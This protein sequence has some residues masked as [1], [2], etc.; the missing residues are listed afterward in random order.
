MT[1][2]GY[3]SE[4]RIR[5]AYS[6]SD[7]ALSRSP[8]SASLK[9]RAVSMCHHPP[10][11]DMIRLRLPLDAKMQ[12]HDRFL[13]LIN[14]YTYLHQPGNNERIKW[15]SSIKQPKGLFGS[16]HKPPQNTVAW[17]GRV[18]RG[19]SWHA[20]KRCLRLSP[21]MMPTRICKTR[22][23]QHQ[24]GGSRAAKERGVQRCAQPVAQLLRRLLGAPW[25]GAF[26]C[27]GLEATGLEESWPAAVLTGLGAAEVGSKQGRERSRLE[28]RLAPIRTAGSWAGA[29]PC[30][31]P[32]PW[33]PP[34][35]ELVPWLGAARG[36]RRR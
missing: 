8:A 10:S 29:P 15:F 36:R 2:H 14:L 35:V 13:T 1:W 33:I 3:Q 20:T 22:D 28:L 26:L 30:A 9:K 16:G 23:M 17:R 18:R 4:S 19:E 11:A 27:P 34:V 24:R 21:A 25:P 6:Q 32:E 5:A 12:E 31:R 7:V